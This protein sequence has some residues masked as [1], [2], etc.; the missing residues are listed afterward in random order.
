MQ[1][2]ATTVTFPGGGSTTT[3]PVT[4]T[5]NATDNVG[6]ASVRVSIRNNTTLQWWNGSSWGPFT[7]VLATLS[8]PGGSSTN[9]SY[10]FNPPST[11]NFG[12]QVRS[13]DTSNNVGANTTWRNFTLT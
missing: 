2:P 13:V 3:S 10:V 6:V 1:A 7:Y 4:I 5:G 9:W 11:G 12:L 8:A